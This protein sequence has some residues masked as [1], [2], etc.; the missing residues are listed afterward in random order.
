MVVTEI[1]SKEN[2]E[3]LAKARK[4]YGS[5]TQILVAV[6]ELSELAAVCTKYPRYKSTERA[7]REL[8]KKALDEVADVLIVLDH[9]VNIFELSTKEVKERIE[10]KI[11]RLNRW[12]QDSDSMD[13]TTIDREVHI[14]Q[15]DIPKRP[16]ATCDYRGDFKNLHPDGVCIK[17][18]QG[19]SKYKPREEGNE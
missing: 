2:R 3:T 17:C 16:C 19:E 1:L 18:M 12:M 5:T 11:D 6:E 14:P 4:T 8:H 10:G 9:I 15:K 13:Q 7:K